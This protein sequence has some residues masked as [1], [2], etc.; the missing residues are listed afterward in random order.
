MPWMLTVGMTM[1]DLVTRSHRTS[2]KYGAYN[3]RHD[4]LLGF[5]YEKMSF[6]HGWGTKHGDTH[7]S[8]FGEFVH[9]P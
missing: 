2:Q 1:I 9:N 8:D 4:V 3:R 7:I 6:E 5:F